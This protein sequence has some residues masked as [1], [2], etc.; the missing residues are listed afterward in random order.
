MSLRSLAAFAPKLGRV[1]GKPQTAGENLHEH[2]EERSRCGRWRGLL[3]VQNEPEKRDNLHEQSA[4]WRPERGNDDEKE[5]IHITNDRQ[6]D[7]KIL[8]T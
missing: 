1:H 7:G 4:R 2:A 6:V 8:M 5:V 3:G